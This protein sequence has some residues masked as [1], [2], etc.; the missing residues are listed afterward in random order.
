[1]SKTEQEPSTN[2]QVPQGPPA[3][4]ASS[5]SA[6]VVAP[7]MDAGLNTQGNDMV[8]TPD[9]TAPTAPVAP[10]ASLSRR[11]W[12]KSSAFLLDLW[13]SFDTGFETMVDGIATSFSPSKEHIT[14]FTS[15]ILAGAAGYAVFLLFNAFGIVT[16]ENE[17]A[18]EALFNDVAKSLASPYFLL[19][20]FLTSLAA[21]FGAGTGKD[22]ISKYLIAPFLDL[23]EHV[24]ML[25]FGV[26]LAWTFVDE[27]HEFKLQ[28]LL[29]VAWVGVVLVAFS[30]GC[31]LAKRFCRGGYAGSFAKLHRRVLVRIVGGSLSVLFLHMLVHYPEQHPEIRQR[32]QARGVEQGAP[33]YAH[34]SL[35]EPSSRAASIASEAPMALPASSGAST[36]K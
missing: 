35:P 26:S 6:E 30:F 21:V 13:R 12:N 29:T 16:L 34:E 15:P 3:S 22:I 14:E 1:M 4:A 11:A 24:L 20:I 32:H 8:E 5:P 27:I 25:A 31:L 9:E 2:S 33:S 23:T 28:T 19:A 7:L 36:A 18:A 17:S 10:K